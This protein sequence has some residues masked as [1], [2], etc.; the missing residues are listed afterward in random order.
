M[1][2]HTLLINEGLQQVSPAVA[3]NFAL[4]ALGSDSDRMHSLLQLLGI[5]GSRRTFLLLSHG[6]NAAAHVRHSSKV[7]MIRH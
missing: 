2:L 7:Q 3:A 1:G 6:A 5:V 4:V